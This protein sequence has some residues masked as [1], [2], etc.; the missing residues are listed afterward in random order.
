MDKLK[1]CVKY[2]EYDFLE[3]LEDLEYQNYE[4]EIKLIEKLRNEEER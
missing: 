1:D 4:D 2:D 3:N